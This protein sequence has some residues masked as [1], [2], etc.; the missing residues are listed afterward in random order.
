MKLVADLHISPKTV[1]ALRKSGFAISGVT[2]HLPPTSTDRQIIELAERLQASIVT[3]ELD[4]SR[5]IAESGKTF[6]SI[7]SLRLGDVSHRRVTD[8]L[9]RL[10]PTVEKDLEEG[11]D[12]SVDEVGVRIRMLPIK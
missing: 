5:L 10:L 2:D 12:I 4:F 6:P 1:H 7:L 11:A 3:Q 8:V 9:M